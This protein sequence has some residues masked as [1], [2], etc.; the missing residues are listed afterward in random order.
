M[1]WNIKWFID[2]K[3]IVNIKT[4]KMTI[5]NDKSQVHYPLDKVKEYEYTNYPSFNDNNSLEWLRIENIYTMTA[6]K[7]L[8]GF[9]D[10]K[11]PKVEGEISFIMAILWMIKKLWTYYRIQEIT[12]S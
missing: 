10:Y 11:S 5:S 1:L 7:E 4:Y 12:K 8:D 6:R 9:L 3:G 2:N